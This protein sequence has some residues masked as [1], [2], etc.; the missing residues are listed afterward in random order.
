MCGHGNKLLLLIAVALLLVGYAAG[1][2]G[3]SFAKEWI[4]YR[5]AVA[6]DPELYAFV[7]SLEDAATHTSLVML[8]IRDHF[9]GPAVFY[10]NSAV[11]AD[12]KAAAFDH[13]LRIIATTLRTAYPDHSMYS[14]MLVS[15]YP[16]T[17]AEGQGT[18]LFGTI[19]YVFGSEG[20]DRFIAGDSLH[21]LEEDELH[22]VFL[23]TYH[24]GYRIGTPITRPPGYVWP[25]E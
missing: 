11:P 2:W 23:W 21:N 3:E 13:E 6:A 10:D 24:G 18:N 5:N 20:I 16:T 7:E 14:I 19:E 12:S 4:E 1:K 17:I 25:W 8:Q 9:V 15:A 22:Y